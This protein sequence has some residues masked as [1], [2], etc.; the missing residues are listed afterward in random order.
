MAPS[1]YVSSPLE[2]GSH[3][4]NLAR[5]IMTRDSESEPDH[6][7]TILLI[8]LGLCALFLG[9]VTAF[10]TYRRRQRNLHRMREDA[11]ND[12]QEAKLG[13]YESTT[14]LN[15]LTIETKHNGRASTILIRRDSN[16]M[17]ANPNSPPNSPDNVPEI[18]ITVPDEVDEKGQL[19]GPRVLVVRVGENATVGLEPMTEEQLPPYQKDDKNGFYSVDMDQIGGLKEKD[20]TQFQ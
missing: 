14:N 16:P 5:A 2:A 13:M 18:H 3:I 20:R 11:L 6:K 15:G 7:T 1:P 8:V 17:L 9:S 4:Q 10:I 12:Y 19:R